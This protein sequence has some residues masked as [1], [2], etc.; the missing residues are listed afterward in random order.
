MF[1]NTSRQREWS[2]SG[3][4]QELLRYLSLQFRSWVTHPLPP[5]QPL[6]HSI[7]GQF[8]VDGGIHAYPVVSENRVHREEFRHLSRDRSTLALRRTERCSIA[9]LHSTGGAKTLERRVPVHTVDEE[10]T[11]VLRCQSEPLADIRDRLFRLSRIM[12]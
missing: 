8:L 11:E 5:T 3:A 10:K 9:V 12:R 1:V 7:A 4:G 2:V 6:T